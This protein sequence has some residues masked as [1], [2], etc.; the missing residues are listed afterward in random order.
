MQ[1][2]DAPEGMTPDCEADDCDESEDDGYC[3]THEKNAVTKPAG[4]WANMRPFMLETVFG[5]YEP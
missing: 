5:V 2:E 1:F 4:E 3:S